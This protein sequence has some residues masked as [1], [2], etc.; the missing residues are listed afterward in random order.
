M[1]APTMDK[2][3]TDSNKDKADRE[4]ATTPKQP[5]EEPIKTTISFKP[6]AYKVLDEVAHRTH[7]SKRDIIGDLIMDKY[8]EEYAHVLD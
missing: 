6:A 2:W 4:K 7:K 5:K 8:G 3:L 1:S